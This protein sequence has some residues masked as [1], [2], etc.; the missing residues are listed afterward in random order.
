MASNPITILIVDDH[1]L[2][3]ES[4]DILLNQDARFKVVGTAKSGEEGIL[5]AKELHPDI[6][7]M[8]VQLGD[9]SG[10]EATRQLQSEATGAK[11]IGVSMFAQPA[12]VRKMFSY[13]AKGYVTKGSS[14]IEMI[15]AII[16]VSEGKQYI[17]KEM[18]D[19]FT[20]MALEKN[21]GKDA[22]IKSL[23]NRELEII[24]LVIEGLTSN[25]IAERLGVSPKTVEVHRYN[26]L[27]KLKLKN[28]SSLVDFVNK[29]LVSGIL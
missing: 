14:R 18:K 12:Y 29:N 9:K 11:I 2:V 3:R 5:I 10:I 4:W 26:I 1:Q 6:I 16:E 20:E 8:D 28:T 25:N 24:K 21:E 22:D 15:T 19:K 23:T 27:R 7:L 13:G 17:C